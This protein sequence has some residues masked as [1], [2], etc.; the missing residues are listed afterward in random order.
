MLTKGRISLLIAAGGLLLVGLLAAALFVP[1]GSEGTEETVSKKKVEKPVKM[2]ATVN[3]L[4]SLPGSIGLPSVKVEGTLPSDPL[5]AKPEAPKEAAKPTIVDYKVQSG[6]AL[7]KIAKKYGC[8]VEDIYKLNDGLTAANANKIRV[9]QVIRVPNG[10]GVV[11]EQPAEKAES[12]GVPQRVVKAEA[13]DTA[14]S[15]AIEYYGSRSLFRMIVDANPTLPWSDRLKGGEE[16][17][18]PAYGEQV[19]SKDSKAEPAATVKKEEV[20]ATVERDS[21]IPPR[22]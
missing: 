15:L 21:L 1:S 2:E 19:Q 4:A 7:S 20:K 6:D 14:F 12:K 5:S 8:K 13:G 17:I 9:G 22:R 18:L 11:V 16:V 3:P 10:P